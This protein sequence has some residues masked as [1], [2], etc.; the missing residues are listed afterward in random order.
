[1][2]KFPL[3]LRV[4]FPVVDRIHPQ[5][6]KF[7]TGVDSKVTQTLMTALLMCMQVLLFHKNVFIVKL[8]T[9]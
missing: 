5:S 8:S 9:K 7:A 4:K 6:N 3:M 1:M 2:L